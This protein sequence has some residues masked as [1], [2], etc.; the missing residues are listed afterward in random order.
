MIKMKKGIDISY[1]Q[2]TVDFN[3]VKADGIKFV[4]LREGYRKTVDT[5]FFEYVKGCKAAGIPVMGVYHFSYALNITQAKEEAA[6]CIKQV[7]KAGLD[8]NT[9]IFFDFEYDTVKK[10]K[11]AGVTLDKDDCIAHSKAFCEYVE[12]Q[13][14]KAGIYAN[15]DYYKNWYSK[16]LI[17]KYRFWLAD[18]SGDADYPCLFQQYSSKGKVNGIS[19]NVDMN[20]Y[21]GEESNTVSKTDI[22]QQVIDDAVDFAVRMAKDN[23]HG[24]SQSTRSLYNITNPKSFDC[25]SL[26]C[27]AFYY[28]F[29]TNGL[30]EAATY[31]KNNCSYTGNMLKMTNCGFEIVAKNQTAH[32]AMKKGD[33]ELNTTYHTA[34]AID[35]DNIVHAR[36]SEGTKDTKDG[37]GNEIRT[38]PWYLYSHGWT[39]R[40]RFTGKGLNLSGTKKSSAT[41]T[42]TTGGTNYMFE[43]KTVQYG[44]TGTSVLLLQEILKARGYTDSNGKVLELDQSAGNAT[45]SALKKYQKERGLEVDGICGSATWTDLIAI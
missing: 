6:F 38:Q 29:V 18:Y 5:R 40:L 14:Y 2:G 34:L 30:T 3:K 21:F 7:K 32:A 16:E 45:V 9:I 11:S 28:A 12:E 42:T 10:A 37:S 17:N 1:W 35:S 36:S 8:K 44:S 20:Y 41:T 27:T 13:G 19:G 23:T 33:I 24:Y 25:S 43:P 26:V 4:L 39:H 31:L 22:V 15:I